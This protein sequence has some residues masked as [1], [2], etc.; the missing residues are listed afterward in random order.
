MAGVFLLNIRAGKEIPGAPTFTFQL[1]VVPSQQ[2]AAGEVVIFMD[3]PNQAK[4]PVAG[5]YIDAGTMKAEHHLLHLQS[6]AIG[7]SLQAD[8][9]LGNG[10]GGKANIRYFDGERLQTF[11]DLPVCEVG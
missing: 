1:G 9:T 4:L 8:I 11:N 2:R 7:R 3:S 5:T 6:E 10:W